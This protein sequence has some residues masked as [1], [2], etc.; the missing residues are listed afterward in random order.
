MRTGVTMNAGVFVRRGRKYD[1][2]PEYA[3]SGTDVRTL[4]GMTVASVRKDVEQSGVYASKSPI[5]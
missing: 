3:E 5:L 1:T 4:P 2:L